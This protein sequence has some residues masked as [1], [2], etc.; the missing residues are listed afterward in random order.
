MLG[1]NQ[2]YDVSGTLRS[3]D[4]ILDDLQKWHRGFF[5]L[6]DEVGDFNHEPNPGSFKAS[7]GYSE[8]EINETLKT[9]WWRWGDLDS[10]IVRTE[11]ENIEKVNRYFY[12][13]NLVTTT[14]DD[15]L[16]FFLKGDQ[17]GV[18]I[19]PYFLQ[20]KTNF[21]VHFINTYKNIINNK[22]EHLRYYNYPLLT[23]LQFVSLI[24]K[25]LVIIHPWSE[26]NGR[27]T[28]LIQDGLANF[29][30]LPAQASGDLMDIDVTTP[31]QAYYEKM[32]SYTMRNLVVIDNC[33]EGYERSSQSISQ[34]YDCR[35]IE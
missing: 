29:Y 8:S 31:V 25:W 32:Y 34:S 13:H 18:I 11:L 14:T 22:Y 17:T 26:G 12:Q 7:P 5:Q 23:P 35:I 21:L 1:M 16:N 4:L 19:N 3:R 30:D 9:Y 28:R 20:S 24:Q 33:I 10:E 2:V 15:R 6:S 27:M